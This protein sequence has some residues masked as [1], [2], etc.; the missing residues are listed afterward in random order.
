M[1]DGAFLERSFEELFTANIKSAAAGKTVQ[2][3][4]GMPSQ[5]PRWPGIS[6]LASFRV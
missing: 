1:S 6:K 2:R 4:S 5:Q 3:W